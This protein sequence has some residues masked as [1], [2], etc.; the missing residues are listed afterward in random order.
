[1]KSVRT[2]NRSYR[3]SAATIVAK[4]KCD[5][6]SPKPIDEF[7]DTVPPSAGGRLKFRVEWTLGIHRYG[8]TSK[9][10]PDGPGGDSPEPIG[11]CAFAV[12]VP[13]AA[14]TTIRTPAVTIR[15]N[16]KSSLASP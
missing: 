2:E 12:D 4:F 8:A 16:I 9:V 5:T 11:C 15:F 3:A 13:P 6:K 1:M 7:A 14:S 10:Q